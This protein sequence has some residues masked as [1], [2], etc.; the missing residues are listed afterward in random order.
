MYAHTPSRISSS[1]MYFSPV[2][3]QKM[4]VQSS[5]VWCHFRVQKKYILVQKLAKEIPSNQI[6]GQCCENNPTKSRQVKSNNHTTQKFTWFGNVYV[7]RAIDGLIQKENRNTLLSNT[8]SLLL[9]F[10]HFLTIAASLSLFLL[11]N[12]HQE[13]S[14]K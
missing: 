5:D 7:Y 9:I 6:S 11:F 4:K 8:M 3:I 14:K 13:D 10:S 1:L 12:T 2:C